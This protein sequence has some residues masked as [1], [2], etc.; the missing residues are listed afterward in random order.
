MLARVARLLIDALL[1]PLCLGCKVVV[2]EPGTLCPSCWSQVVFLAP[3]FCDR[4]GLPFEFDPGPGAECG[5]CLQ[6]PPR[7]GR[8]RSVFRYDDASK[9]M[10]LRFKHGDRIEAAPAFA[11]WMVRAGA[12]LLAEAD[13]LVP[14]PLHRWR[15]VSRRYNQAAL[16]AMGVARLS[17]VAAI[18]DLLERRRRTPPQGH[19]GHD[20]RARNVAGA[21][22]VH[23]GRGAALAGKRVVLIDDVL[24]SGATVSECV[25]VLVRGGAA[26]VDVLTLGRVVRV[27]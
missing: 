14:V 20:A 22:A 2:A 18:P 26:S 21:F 27:D 1:P 16:L 6:T 15:L 10:V 3:P 25:K 7:Y 4:C 24:T 19:L 23:P 13:V 5:Q 9:V 12:D 17:G 11:R 8:A